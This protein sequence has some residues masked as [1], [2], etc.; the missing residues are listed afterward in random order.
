M[1]QKLSP[2][3]LQWFEK[4]GISAETLQRNGV[5]MEIRGDENAPH[6]AHPFYKDGNIVNVKYRQLPKKFHQTK[7]G[8]QIMYGFDDAK[9]PLPSANSGTNRLL[10]LGSTP[11]RHTSVGVLLVFSACI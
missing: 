5:A 4:R 6:I 7:G 2:E 9:V 11:T 10:P 8:E 3:F 1:L